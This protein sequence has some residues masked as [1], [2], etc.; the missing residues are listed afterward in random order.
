MVVAGR[1]KGALDGCSSA[2]NSSREWTGEN[3][4]RVARKERDV[5]EW[6][7]ERRKEERNRIKRRSDEERGKGGENHCLTEPRRPAAA[8]AAAS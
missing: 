6:R 4:E 5:E 2:G 1:E 3:G 8:V 7:K